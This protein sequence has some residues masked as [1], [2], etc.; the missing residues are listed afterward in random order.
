ME[1]LPGSLRRLPSFRSLSL[2]F[3]DRMTLPGWLG[4]LKS[5]KKL[6]IQG[7]KNLRSLPQLYNL[8]DLVIEQNDELER[9]CESDVNRSKFAHIK[10]KGFWPLESPRWSNNYIIPA[11]SLHITWADDDRYWRSHSIPDCRYHFSGIE[12]TDHSSQ[13]RC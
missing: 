7:C 12:S 2:S 6:S 9:W 11:I 10:Q 1:F 5:L 4:D 8:Q 3:C 13:I